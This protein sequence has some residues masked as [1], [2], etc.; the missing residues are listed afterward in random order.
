MKHLTMLAL[1]SCTVLVGCASGG[2]HINS[3]TFESGS[4]AVKRKAFIRR[5]TEAGQTHRCRWRRI[6]LVELN[7]RHG[8][9][10]RGCWGM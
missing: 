4:G 10:M 6:N 5:P 3:R 1:A 2:A 7:R 9:D 8:G